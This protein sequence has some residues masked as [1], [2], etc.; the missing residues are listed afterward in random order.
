MSL[1]AR[2]PAIGVR[3]ITTAISA[4]WSE[5]QPQDLP[6]LNSILRET[7]APIYQYP[8]WNEPYRRIWVTPRYLVWGNGRA[9]LAIL[10][11]LTIGFGRTKIG[12]VFRGPAKLSPDFEFDRGMFRELFAWASAN[13]FMFLRFTHSDP[14]VLADLSAAG[15]SIDSDSFPYLVDYPV[16]TQDY[17]VEQHDSDEETL[18]SFDRE[19]RRKIRR[20]TEAGYDFDSTDSP[21]A[22]EQ[23]WPLFEDCARRKHF[24]LE[25]PMG[26]YMDLMRRAQQHDSVR[27]YRASLDGRVVGCTLAFRDR[28]TSHCLLAAFDGDH[29]LC[30]SL[31]HWRSMRDMYRLG[32]R[33]YNMGPGPGALARFKS[34]FCPSPVRYPNPLTIV[35][36]ETPFKLWGKAFVPMAK[37]L[38]PMLRKLAFQRALTR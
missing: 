9:P 8:F 11:I 21:A 36:K 37:Q 33:R 4:G 14:V 12:L 25:R 5:A 32:V 27:L 2:I 29:K 31:L 19:A 23:A 1:V 3:S 26:F 13:G 24:R 15:R 7:G 30:A 20:G 28:N 6:R 22:L 34:T 10:S 35:L 16:L 18:A 38:Q 17:V